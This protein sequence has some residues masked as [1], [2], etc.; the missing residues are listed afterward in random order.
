MTR[1]SPVYLDV[2]SD[3]E[4]QV[5]ESLIRGCTTTETARHLRISQHTV[6]SHKGRIFGKLGAR[7][8]A[9]AA[10][11]YMGARRLRRSEH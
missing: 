5:M 3:R 10:A 8:A 7:S 1:Q 6:K 11:I 9:H 4:I 2:L